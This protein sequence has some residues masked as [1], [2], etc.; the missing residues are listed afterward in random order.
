[1]STRFRRADYTFVTEGRMTE[2]IIRE[3]ETRW[4]GGCACGDVR[5]EYVGKPV[6]S[7]K[8]HCLD[9]Q[10]WSGSGH[11]AMVWGW[12]DGFRLTAGEPR[13]SATRGGS[14]MHVKR[15]LCPS[16][17]CPVNVEIERIPNVVGMIASS[18]DDPGRFAPEFELWTEQAPAWDLLDPSLTQFEAGFERQLIRSLLQR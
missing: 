1:V 11:L 18:L 6:L 10:A 8:C 17:G 4:E 12:A 9:C 3:R 16:C 2:Q 5:Y 13:H 14:G 7:L 15:G